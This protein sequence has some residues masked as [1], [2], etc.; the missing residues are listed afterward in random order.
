MWIDG[1]E[2]KLVPVEPTPEMRVAGKH[3]IKGAD[4]T[5]EGILAE[6]AYRSMIDAA[7]TPPAQA[8][9]QSAAPT[10]AIY[11]AID[12]LTT[13]AADLRECHTRASAPDDW[14][15]EV[16]A[17]AEYDRI[18]RCVAAL[19]A[20]Y[21]KPQAGSAEPVAWVAADTL[22]SP[23]PRCVS[24]L[25][26]VSQIDQD[27]GREYVPLYAAPVAAQAPAADA[28]QEMVNR[29]LDASRASLDTAILDWIEDA[30]FYRNGRGELTFAFNECWS[31][32]NYPSLR[33]AIQAA[34]QRESGGGV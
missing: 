24:S 14:T 6:L 33:A 23:H 4:T 17:K 27:R 29:M 5:F 31:A 34:M 20:R 16:E 26:Y 2:W 22:H 10:D 11:D 13:I 18:L 12:I 32:G 19:R 3:T 25:A 28:Q 8:S 1:R 7:P 21:G 30:W 9:G 15:G